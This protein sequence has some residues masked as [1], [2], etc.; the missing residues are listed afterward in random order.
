M[1]HQHIR[2]NLDITAQFPPVTQELVGLAFNQSL[3]GGHHPRQHI[4]PNEVRPGA[5]CDRN[6]R[7]GI[8]A[9]HIHPDR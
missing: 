4:D 5:R 7:M 3:I 1:F 2:Q 6:G 8:I 9:Q